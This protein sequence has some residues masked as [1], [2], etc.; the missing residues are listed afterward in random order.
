[1]GDQVA[2][3]DEFGQPLYSDPYESTSTSS[4][5]DAGGTSVADVFVNGQDRVADIFV[6]LFGAAEGAVTHGQEVV[7]SVAQSA[8]ETVQHGQDVVGG[9]VEDAAEA[10]NPW[11]LAG[12]GFGLTA[13]G[14]LVT[15]G[16]GLVAG[17]AADQIL[18]G[19]SGT[20]W[21]IKQATGRRRR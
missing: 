20:A 15:V 3:Y 8:A 12:L 11:N 5:A 14:T 19:G 18:M 10:A 6:A 17:F 2:A 13:G 4:S 1:M 16:V 7:G 21:L 9:A